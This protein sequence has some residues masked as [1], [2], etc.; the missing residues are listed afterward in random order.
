MAP[1]RVAMGWQVHGTDLHEWTGRRRTART[2]SPGQELERVDGHL[3]RVPGIGL[4]V[5]VADC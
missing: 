4:L 5:L 1:E 3:T 2:R